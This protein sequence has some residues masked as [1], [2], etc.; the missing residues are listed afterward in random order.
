MFLERK[1]SQAG[2]TL[3]ETL[4]TLTIIGILA[5]I[6]YPAL[7]DS[8]RRGNRAEARAML[9]ENAQYMERFFNEN[10][11]YSR[12]GSGPE[13]S[14]PRTV[15]PAG[16]TGAKVNYTIALSAVSAS[17]FTLMAT[18]TNGMASDDCANL[19][20]TNLGRKSTDGTLKNG[21]TSVTCWEK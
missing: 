20:L 5:A 4:I 3:I 6:T 19:T 1:K 8:G 14:L 2:F 12:V 21:M 11:S 16:A 13:P 18:A 9:M 17:A 15:A 7:R 10:N